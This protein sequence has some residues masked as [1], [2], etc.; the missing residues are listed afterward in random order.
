MRA[1]LEA[2]DRKLQ[3]WAL[4]PQDITICKKGDGSDWLVGEGAYGKARQ[5]PSLQTPCCLVPYRDCSSMECSAR[6]CSGQ[7]QNPVLQGVCT[8]VAGC[9]RRGKS[10]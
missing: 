4:R 3:G 6:A 10:L 5:H 9:V 8:I 2:F 1:E 7:H